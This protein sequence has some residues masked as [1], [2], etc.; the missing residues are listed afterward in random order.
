[1]SLK[2]RCVNLGLTLGMLAALLLLPVQAAEFHVAKTGNDANKGSA[3]KPLLT[4]QAAA[5]R[6]QPGDTITVHAGVYRERVNPPRGGKSDR[7]R[8]TYQAA[9]GDRVTITGSEPAKGWQKVAQDTWKL[10]LTNAC[11]GTF[12]PFAEKVDGDWFLPFGRTHHRGCVYLNGQWLVEAPDLATAMQPAGQKP[13][14]FAT[15]DTNAGNTVIHAQFPGVDPNAA[16]VEINVRPTVF[17]PAQTNINYLTL[18]GFD[19]RNAATTWA[20]PTAGQ[21]GLVTAYWCKGWIIENNEI[22]YSRCSGLALGKYSDQWDGKRGTTEGYYLTVDD[23]LKKDGWSREKIGGHLVRKNHIHD[24]GQAGIVG[25]MGC[26]FSTI[27]DNEIHEINRQG[28]WAGAEMAGIKFHGAID[29]VIARNH[30]HHCDHFGGMWLDWMTQ[31]TQIVGNLLHDNSGWG[32]DFTCEVNHGPYLVANN[33]FLSTKTEWSFSRGGAYVHNLMCGTMQITADSRKTPYLK[34]HSTEIV[35]M[36]DCPIGDV[37]LYNNLLV[38]P[39]GFQEYNAATEPVKAAGN[40]FLKGAQPSKFDSEAL[41]KPD[42]NPDI[43][44]IRKADGWYLEMN[45]DSKW[46]EE[47]KRKLVTM[48]LLGKAKVPDLPFVNPDGTPLKVDTDYF[49]KPRSAANPTPGPF[50][51]PGTGRLLLKVR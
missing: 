37:R 2:R 1:M 45:F 20:A 5:E 12:N 43:K 49:G 46:I 6:A 23:A 30:I 24:C 28:I 17:T 32:G 41:L 31:G 38:A 7:R 27:V 51:N 40:V 16:Q 48:E 39:N 21:I 13:L 35:G 42:F 18:R 10:V 29:V 3:R 25:S 4:I 50:E 15:V 11:F 19:L 8:I 36:H 34:P 22:S 9:P 26:A 33:I 47:Q 14:W 44:V